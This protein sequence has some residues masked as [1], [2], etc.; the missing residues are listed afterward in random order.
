MN[1]KNT[2]IPARLKPGDKVGIAA[3]ASPFDME[4]YNR[5]VH[6]LESMGLYLSVLD[7]IFDKKY[8]SCRV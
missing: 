5:G 2:L 4:N 8:I 3:P 1:S 7:D 6:V